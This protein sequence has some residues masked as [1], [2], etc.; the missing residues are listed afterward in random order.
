LNGIIALA[1]WT[2]TFLNP[3]ASILDGVN[4]VPAASEHTISVSEIWFQKET[5]GSEVALSRSANY[6]FGPLQPVASL[7]RTDQNAF[8]V[9]AGF[10]NTINISEKYRLKLRFVPGVYAKGNDVNL[11]G[12]L[13]FNSEIG[14]ERNISDH[15]SISIAFDHRSSGDL[16]SYNPGMETVKL[17][18]SKKFQ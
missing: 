8:W 6:S 2:S 10:A 13:M 1:F 18:F 16:W 5:I 4:R 9:G 14:L 7:S 17:R 3:E 11:G 12:W 15:W